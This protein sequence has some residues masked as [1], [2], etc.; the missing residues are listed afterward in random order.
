[1]SLRDAI[2]GV[3]AGAGICMLLPALF[4]FASPAPASGAERASDRTIKAHR[5]GVKAK[6]TRQPSSQPADD[7]LHDEFADTT[8]RVEPAAVEQEP[9]LHG[10]GNFEGVVLVPPGLPGTGMILVEPAAETAPVSET[11]EKPQIP[12]DQIPRDLTE[13]QEDPFESVNR[14]F[15][16]VNTVLDHLILEPSA[17]IYRTVVPPPVRQGV[18]N[19]VRN[20]ESPVILA[21]DIL[22]GNRQRA[23]DTM[24]RF[25]VNSTI[26]IG[27][28]VDAAGYMGV[29]YHPEDFGQTLA[30]W[31]A[32]PGPYMVVP[33]LGPSNPRDLAGTVV[34]SAIN[35]LTWILFDA[36][37]EERLAPSAVELVA[38]R[39]AILDDYESLR[40][41][42]PD[43]YVSVRDIYGQKRETEIS[44]GDVTGEPIPGGVTSL[45][46][47]TVMTTVNPF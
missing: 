9:P 22:Q 36:P 5:A 18:S 37:L 43:V 12:G 19:A 25:M 3:I 2:S 26:G 28:L 30:V 20:I 31:G 46:P 29:Q 15:F 14:L 38:G 33:V 10:H 13:E 32:G 47:N 23:S 8:I 41:T 24:V 7:Y 39:E 11:T 4:L 1:M 42:S 44:N 6:R 16:A 35:P 45:P 17:R 27:G 40:K 34:D 21:N